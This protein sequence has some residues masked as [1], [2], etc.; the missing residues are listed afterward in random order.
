MLLSIVIVLLHTW[1]KFSI[2]TV[3]VAHLATEVIHVSHSC[4]CSSDFIA[5]ELVLFGLAD[6]GA[7][8]CSLF[9]LSFPDVKRSVLIPDKADR[10]SGGWYLV[11]QSSSVTFLII[12]LINDC[13]RST[14]QSSYSKE[15]SCFS[16]NIL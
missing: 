14:F 6:R 9:N 5:N 12:R 10:S 3:V 13:I 7:K 11:V 16:I 1:L 4:D 8:R 15:V 2:N